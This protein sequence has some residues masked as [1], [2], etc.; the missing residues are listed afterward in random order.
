[1]IIPVFIGGLVFPSKG[2]A[3]SFFRGIRDRYPDRAEV[4]QADGD[5][6][7]AL[8][9]VHPESDSKIGSGIAS[10][11]VDTDAEFRRTRHFVVHRTD[12]SSTDFSF[13]AC[14]DGRNPRR[15]SLEAMRRAVEGQVVAFRDRYFA[16]SPEG[17]CPLR[18]VPIRPDSYHVDHAPP[19][20]FITLAFAWLDQLGMA[21][22][23]V[24]ITPPGDNQIVA[25]MTDE[26]QMASW[27]RFHQAHASLRML[28][29]TANLSDANRRS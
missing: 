23:D 25:R 6:L 19:G 27:A 7:R 14:I 9:S 11:S 28:S 12:G 3:K 22:G 17:V 15:D 4:G 2:E 13:N 18:G 29:P 16:S 10:F 21:L 26:G 1:M 8:L 20:K 24:A 5:H